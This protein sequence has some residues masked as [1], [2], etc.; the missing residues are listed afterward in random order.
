MSMAEGNEG[1][2]FLPS[3]RALSSSIFFCLLFRRLSRIPSD[4]RFMVE[5]AVV[6]LGRL[7]VL[8]KYSVSLPFPKVETLTFSRIRPS[9]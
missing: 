3:L 2:E 1:V 8:K 4:S 6:L 5:G 7:R 9:G